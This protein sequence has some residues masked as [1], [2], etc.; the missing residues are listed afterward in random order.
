LSGVGQYESALDHAGQALEIRRKL[1]E[2]RP[3]RFEPDLATSLNNYASHLRA[4]G[5]YESGLEHALQALEIHRKLAEARP[6]RFE[7][8]LATSLSNYA[9]HLS[10]VGRY[11]PAIDHARQALEIRRRL[12][13][14]R[15]DR[16]EPD[17]ATSLSSYAGHLGNVGEY[18]SGLDHARQA[19]KIRRKL[20]E[21]LPERFEPDLF[22]LACNLSILQWLAGS[23]SEGSGFEALCVIPGSVPLHRR[24]AAEVQTAFVTALTSEPERAA[25]FAEVISTWTRSTTTRKSEI[26]EY[27]LCGAAWSEK[28]AQKEVAGVDWRAVLREDMARRGGLLPRWMEDVA[29]RLGFN[30]NA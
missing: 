13:E 6:E 5:Q 4:V 1:A 8:D 11:G 26:R 7:P 27:F 21:A 14:A 17:L 2:A 19:L 15:P 10:D 25:A 3:D 29:V 22:S 12:A 28:F 9:S 18:E 30:W 20:A 23:S 16:F 24:H